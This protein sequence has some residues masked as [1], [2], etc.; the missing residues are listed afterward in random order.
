VL[1]SSDHEN[2]SIAMNYGGITS[3]EF[4]S[5]LTIAGKL[6]IMDI[7]QVDF[8]KCFRLA[9]LLNISD[10]DNISRNFLVA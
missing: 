4:F 1:L 10:E 7:N 6:T 2:G 3:K 5:S 8:F 9:D